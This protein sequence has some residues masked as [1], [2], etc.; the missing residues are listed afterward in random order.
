MP[1]SEPQ[2]RA[3]KKWNDENKEQYHYLIKKS[4]TKNFIIKNG[5]IEDVKELVKLANERISREEA[6]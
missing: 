2:K 1:Y 3:N 6:D 4:T 5:T